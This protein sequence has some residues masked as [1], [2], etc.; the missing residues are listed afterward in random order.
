MLNT[1][2]HFMFDV[3]VPALIASICSF[4]VVNV[5]VRADMLETSFTANPSR[6]FVR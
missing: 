2:F 3:I 4:A 1:F 5:L 6:S